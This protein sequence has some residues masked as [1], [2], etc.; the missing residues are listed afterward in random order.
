MTHRVGR[1]GVGQLALGRHVK[2]SSA[3]GDKAI[4]G[5]VRGNLRRDASVV[6]AREEEKGCVLD[7]V[8]HTSVAI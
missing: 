8:N 1:D 2:G 6:G 7:T 4:D 5:R 3:D